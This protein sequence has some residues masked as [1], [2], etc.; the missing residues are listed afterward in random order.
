MKTLMRSTISGRT[1][2][3]N[4]RV[5]AGPGS[6]PF[7]HWCPQLG[8]KP[9]NISI[10]AKLSVDQEPVIGQTIIDMRGR[11][12]AWEGIEEVS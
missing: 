3:R 9:I 4:L 12:L 6:Y 11:K 5:L 1:F 2:P 10:T 7:P 8:A